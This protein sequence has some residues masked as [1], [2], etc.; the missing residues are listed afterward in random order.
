[1]ENSKGLMIK[2]KANISLIKSYTEY[3]DLGYIL[4]TLKWQQL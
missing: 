1:M 3:Q 4:I 2:H